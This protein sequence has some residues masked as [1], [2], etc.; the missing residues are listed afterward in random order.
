MDISVLEEFCVLARTLNFTAAAKGDA[1]DD[2]GL[3]PP[4]EAV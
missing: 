2:L 1:A 3:R 4:R